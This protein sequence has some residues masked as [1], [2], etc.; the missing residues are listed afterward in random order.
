MGRKSRSSINVKLFTNNFQK[1]ENVV[2][3]IF[4][5]VLF[6]PVEKINNNGL[7][8]SLTICLFEAIC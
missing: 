2:V 5:Y 4:H 6:S 3:F 7:L 8:H 1:C